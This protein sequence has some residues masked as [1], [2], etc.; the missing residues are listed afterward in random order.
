MS[1]RGKRRLTGEHFAAVPVEVLKSDA[2]RTLPAYAFRA[3]IAFAAEYRGNNNGDIALTWSTGKPYGIAS[4]KQL[5]ASITM[6]QERQ[7][8]LKTRQGGKR[9]LG[10]CLYA[11]TW[12]PIDE[13]RP[14]I[15]MAP[16]PIPSHAWAKWTS[17]PQRDQ[18][19]AFNGTTG[20]P[21]SRSRAG[22]TVVSMGNGAARVARS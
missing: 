6:L 16:N 7:L 5:V 1:R 11:L 21:P 18:R 14:K 2:C 9:P 4:K 15:D 19:T 12:R 8:I 10:P 20:S 17:A 22:A 3:L 13:L